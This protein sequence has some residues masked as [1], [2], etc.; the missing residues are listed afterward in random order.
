MVP[1]IQG[2]RATDRKK[3]FILNALV[4][5]LVIVITIQTK[6]SLDNHFN[7]D[8]PKTRVSLASLGISFVVSFFAAWSAYWLME[9]VF[10]YG[11]GMLTDSA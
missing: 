4:S 8:A 1:L 7:K 6:S 2:F 9:I 5:A 3:A 11:G 10:G